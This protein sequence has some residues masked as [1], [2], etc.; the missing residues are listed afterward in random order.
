M[1]RQQFWRGNAERVF[2]LIDAPYER[3]HDHG[4]ALNWRKQ[5]EE[6]HAPSQSKAADLPAPIAGTQ[7]GLARSRSNPTA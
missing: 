6:P 7:D 5:E 4:P 2:I 3:I 1:I